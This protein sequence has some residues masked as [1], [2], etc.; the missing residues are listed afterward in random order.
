MTPSNSVRILTLPP[1][2]ELKKRD[3][4]NAIER[5]VGG[6]PSTSTPAD[7]TASPAPTSD[8]SSTVGDGSSSAGAPREA[9]TTA[10]VP[11]PA[12]VNPYT[13]APYEDASSNF[14]AIAYSAMR[15]AV[16][17]FFGPRWLDDVTA[18]R[19]ILGVKA[20]QVCA[21]ATRSR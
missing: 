3:G 11:V 20:P 10:A 5:F 13:G 16:S 2:I 19:V 1:G 7:A 17:P 14:A 6:V 9:L 21:I 18:G 8:S 12:G 4:S 15:S